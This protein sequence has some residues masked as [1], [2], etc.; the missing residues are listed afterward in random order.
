[1]LFS[2]LPNVGIS[3][4]SEMTKMANQFNAINLSQGFPNFNCSPF[5][6]S[7]VEKYMQ[8]AK[9]QYAPME[10]VF[11]LRQAIAEKVK[12]LYKRQYDPVSEITV[13]AGATQAIF[14]AISAFIR[15][16]DEV[17]IFEPAFDCYVPAIKLNGGVPV[18]VSL[19]LPDY[20]IDWM[21]VQKHISSRTRMIIIN[22]PHNPSGSIL[23]QADIE[24]LQKIVAGSKIIVVS[25]EVYEHV[26]FGNEMH[27]SVC[28]FE[29]LANNSIVIS[30]FG[31]TYHT[32]GWKV[33]YALAPANLMAEFRKVHQFIVYAVNT[34]IQ[35]AYAEF[36]RNADDYLNLAAFYEQKR[37]LFC[38]KLEN[39]RFSILPS[40]GTYYQL[41]AYAPISNIR[42][43]EMVE[44]LIKNIGVAA[45]PISVF[46]HE[47]TD[48]KVLRFCFAKDDDTL[49][50]AAKRLSSL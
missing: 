44:N 19:K 22:S 15:E 39:S 33:G 42:D 38:S 14:T 46:Y 25:D 45:I 28:R 8:L 43:V 10:G 12:N 32:T 35:Y 50:E 34:P 16:N 17:I 26:I 11:E 24:K 37:D 29:S 27:Q 41:L 13:T 40:N 36:L 5:L 1:M 21:E 48:N 47:Q 20:H 4:F 23:L 18:F 6:I 3:I 9:N 7:L 30:S 2:K 31:K 49:I